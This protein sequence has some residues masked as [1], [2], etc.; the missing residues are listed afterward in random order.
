[1]YIGAI[2]LAMCWLSG[3][4]WILIYVFAM[5]AVYAVALL[6][7]L[8]L[9]YNVQNELERKAKLNAQGPKWPRNR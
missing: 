6:Y 7:A 4:W 3:K 2:L 9:E 5:L 8:Y 1:M